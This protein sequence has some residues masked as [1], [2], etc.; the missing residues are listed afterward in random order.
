MKQFTSLLF[1]ISLLIL[2]L[3]C[4]SS[5]ELSPDTRQQVKAMRAGMNTISQTVLDF[6]GIAEFASSKNRSIFLDA[7]KMTVTRNTNLTDF[8]IKNI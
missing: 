4:T 1:L 6:S 3:A 7:L 5:G 2:E 8:L